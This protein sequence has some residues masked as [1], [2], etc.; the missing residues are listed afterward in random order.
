MHLKF[1]NSINPHYNNEVDSISNSVTYK[2][3][4]AHKS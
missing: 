2:E 4:E 3:T 1:F